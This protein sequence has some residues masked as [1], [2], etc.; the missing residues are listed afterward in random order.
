MS[1]C[2]VLLQELLTDLSNKIEVAHTR[3]VEDTDA[4]ENAAEAV[5]KPS[6][7]KGKADARPLLS[8]F[9]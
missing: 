5:T 2:I 8:L 9:F 3:G 4:L 1:H 7:N 6:S